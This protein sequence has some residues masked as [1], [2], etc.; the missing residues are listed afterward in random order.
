MDDK[1]LKKIDMAVATLL[2]AF[3]PGFGQFYNG[4]LV[5]GVIFFIT[6]TI[7][8]YGTTYIYWVPY[9]WALS[10]ILF[11]LPAYESIIFIDIIY[12]VVW[13]FSIFDANNDSK[14]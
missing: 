7:L 2:S 5:K 4:K 12:L 8:S 9:S 10:D 3:Y 1:I 13:I 6:A 11:G 14:L